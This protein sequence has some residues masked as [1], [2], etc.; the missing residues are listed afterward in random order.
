MIFFLKR[1]VLK[2][3]VE[4]HRLVTHLL[5]F[6]HSY[7]AILLADET[8]RFGQLQMVYTYVVTQKQHFWKGEL[9]LKWA[10]LSRQY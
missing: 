4:Q 6:L 3:Q 5:D 7:E 1:N 8:T 2:V 10:W 9:S